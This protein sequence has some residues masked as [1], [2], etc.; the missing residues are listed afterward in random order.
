MSEY[1]TLNNEV[2]AMFC[3]MEHKLKEANITYDLTLI[4]GLDQDQPHVMHSTTDPLSSHR[5]L[6]AGIIPKEDG[7]RVG[8]LIEYKE[9]IIPPDAHLRPD[10][11]QLRHRAGTVH[12]TDNL[13]TSPEIDKLFGELENITQIL[14]GKDAK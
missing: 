14:G 7:S 11:T 4:T 12:Y 6:S 13:S 10:C 5:I 2:V 9:K 3:E 1:N 8:R